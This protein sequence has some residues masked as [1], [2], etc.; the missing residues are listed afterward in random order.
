[1]SRRPAGLG[2]MPPISRPCVFATTALAMAACARVPQ[3]VRAGISEA[4]LVA[5]PRPATSA[6]APEPWKHAATLP[7]FRRLSRFPSK[8][9]F[10]ARLEADL[11]VSPEAADAYAAPPYGKLPVGTVLVQR[12]FEGPDGQVRDLLA[13]EKRETGF[14][15]PGDD[16]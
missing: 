14:D 9:H 13:M 12:H 6:P 4:Q 15:A 5:P 8:G 16:W 10:T 7:Q 3:P 11:L 1:M 2:P